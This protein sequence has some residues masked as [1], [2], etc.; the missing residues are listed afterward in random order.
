MYQQIGV[1][2]GILYKKK[3]KREGVSWLWPNLI[4]SSSYHS[5]KAVLAQSK[6]CL[7]GVNTT[8]SSKI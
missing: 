7:F 1:L 3:K 8:V 4:A 2:I 5:L 6:N